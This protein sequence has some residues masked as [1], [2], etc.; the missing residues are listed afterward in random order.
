MNNDIELP[1]DWIFIDDYGFKILMLVSVLADNN[2]A[3]RGTLKTMCE[4]LDISYQK[5]NKDRIIAA[6]EELEGQGYIYHMVEGKIHHVS[7]TNKGLNDNRL[8]KIKKVWVEVIKNYKELDIANNNYVDWIKILKV[9][10]YLLSNDDSETSTMAIRAYELGCSESTFRH[11]LNILL[12][13]PLEEL[14][15]YKKIIRHKTIAGWITDGT[16]IE[17]GY[18][19]R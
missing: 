15:M 8:I 18:Y 14:K 9:F 1:Y 5:K 6:L 11:A 17:V 16:N 4:W 7:I 19:W 2:L 13:L 12:Q 3:Y 10:I